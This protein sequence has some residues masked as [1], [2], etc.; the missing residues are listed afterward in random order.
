PLGWHFVAGHPTR[1]IAVA[2]IPVVLLLLMLA[3]LARRSVRYEATRPPFH[4]STEPPL[5]S[6]PACALAGGLADKDFWDG[7]V[8]VVALLRLHIAAAIALLG[9]FLTVTTRALAGP[10]G[11]AW[12]VLYWAALAGALA[13]L[14]AIVL[15]VA[16]DAAGRLPGAA[17]RLVPLVLLAVAAALLLCAWLYAWLRPYPVLLSARP[18]REL[19]G[20]SAVAGWTVLGIGVVLGLA[21]LSA[22]LGGFSKGTLPGGSWVT[23]MVGFGLLNYGM[24]SLLTWLAHLIGP[25]SS[26][27]G[28]GTLYLPALIIS[29]TPLLGWAY[30]IAVMI[31]L[32]VNAVRWLLS[33]ALP[34]DVATGY[35]QRAAEFIAAQPQQR[36]IWYQSGGSTWQRG[37]A[38]RWYLARAPHGASGLLYLIVVVQVVLALGAWRLHWQAP[39]VIRYAGT[40]I[41]GLLLPALMTMLRAAWSDPVRRRHIAIAWDVGTFWPRSYHPLAPPCYTERAIPDLQRRMW[42]LHDNGGRV[43]LTGHS[44]GTML[45]VA[46]LAQ[47]DRRPLGQDVALVTFGAPLIKLYGWG[48]PAYVDTG[49]LGPLAPGAGG[50]VAGWTNFWYPTDPIAGP[51]GI[52]AVDMEL[53]DPA[54][55]LFVYGQPP[56]GPGGHS[57][58]WQ[59]PRVWTVIDRMAADFTGQQAADRVTPIATE[60]SASSGETGPRR[61]PVNP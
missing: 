15:Y 29:G 59:D 24:L 3:Y 9:V 45:A 16:L 49:V 46:A 4:G 48:F 17:R 34:A 39:A 7:Q 30:I 2:A 13:V 31:F 1:Q 20:L 42:W 50:Q 26:A 37:I 23:L 33:R 27:G 28:P 14:G 22:L 10:A 32:L 38:R 11:Q 5:P 43:L 51:V 19:P 53:P 44:Q 25:V 6:V 52:G 8:S 36:R 58:Y 40:A 54:E 18:A 47:P 41:G 61:D 12:D 35:Q 21:L 60:T 55:S 57:G 56:P